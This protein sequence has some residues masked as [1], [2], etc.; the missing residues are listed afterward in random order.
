MSN[1]FDFYPGKPYIPSLYKFSPPSSNEDIRY[2]LGSGLE[3][4]I[5][6]REKYWSTVESQMWEKVDED[7]EPKPGDVIR[8]HFVSDPITDIELISTAA[9]ERAKRKAIE[10]LR[11]KGYEPYWID[12]KVEEAGIP[13]P[14]VSAYQIVVDGLAEA[15]GTPGVGAIAL[16]VIVILSLILGITISLAVKEYWVYKSYEAI[17]DILT[18]PNVPQ[19]VKEKVASSV[20]SPQ[21]GAGIG[22]VFAGASALVLLVLIIMLLKR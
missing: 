15:K 22:Y 6:E 9:I 20:T 1:E 2:A 19:E 12:V 14:L 18:N 4:Y 16:V 21:G 17:T 7:Y 8:F 13:T 11:K 3:E 5:R 10:E